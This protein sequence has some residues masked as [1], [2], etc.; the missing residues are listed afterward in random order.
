L[1][2]TRLVFEH[3]LQGGDGVAAVFDVR[4]DHALFYTA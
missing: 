1:E 3:L 4:F 2:P